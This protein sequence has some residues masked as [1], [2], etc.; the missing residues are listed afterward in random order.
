MLSTSR[1]ALPRLHPTSAFTRAE[2]Q[3]GLADGTLVRVRRGVVAR[4]SPGPGR[5]ERLVLARGAAFARDATTDFWLSHSTAAVLWGCWTFRLRDRADVTQL[6]PPSIVRRGSD[7][8]HLVARHWTRLP[9]RDRTVLDDLP[10]TTLERTVV[11]CA[12]ALR[13]ASAL[14]VADSG[15]RLGADPVLV[16]EVLAE[17]AGGRGVRQARHVLTL[18]DRASESPGES[19]V[20]WLVH[21]AGLPALDLQVPVSTWAGSFRLDLGWPDLKVAIEFDGA[22]KYTV[23]ADGDATAW[24]MAEKQRHDALV[25]AGWLVLRV[26]WADL[27]QPDR[28]IGRIVNAR[29]GRGLTSR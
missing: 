6:T 2:L 18:A 17:A 11:D 20:R 14:V 29:R 19:V 24:F 7:P 13:G 26:T 3:A 16:D 21:E 28:L 22:V 25:E 15:L 10:V 8:V 12:R 27:E 9:E 5:R 4:T 1:P 23:L